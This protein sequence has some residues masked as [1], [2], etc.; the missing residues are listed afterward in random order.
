MTDF[1][2]KSTSDKIINK[3]KNPLMSLVNI[4]PMYVKGMGYTKSVLM[5]RGTSTA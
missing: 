4:E 5:S 2:V 3:H 1:S